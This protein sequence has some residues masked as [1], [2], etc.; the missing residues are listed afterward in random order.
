MRTHDNVT[1]YYQSDIKLTLDMEQDK[2]HYGHMALND[3]NFIGISMIVHL[4]FDEKWYEHIQIIVDGDVLDLSAARYVA[5][6]GREEE[7]THTIIVQGKEISCRSF[8]I[9]SGVLIAITWFG[10]RIESDNVTYDKEKNE[11]I[12][13]NR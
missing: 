8:D 6:N 13:R 9:L 3:D 2:C 12:V 10:L 11:W 4:L 7:K 1:V 5:D